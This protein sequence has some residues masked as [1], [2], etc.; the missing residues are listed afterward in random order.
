ML[1]EALVKCKARRKH[2][3]E[4]TGHTPPRFHV[5]TP[6]HVPDTDPPTD[7][8]PDSP[9]PRSYFNRRQFRIPIR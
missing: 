1:V 7:P 5:S 3:V 6:E 4:T 8:A 2:S 9:R